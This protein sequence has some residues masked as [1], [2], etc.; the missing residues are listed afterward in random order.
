MNRLPYFILIV[1]LLTLSNTGFSQSYQW[2]LLGSRKVNYT[3]DRDV[4]PV[5]IRKESYRALKLVVKHGG[6]NL[7]KCIVHFENGAKEEI[8]VRHNFLR[9][10]SSRTIDLPGNKRFIEKIEFYYDS[11]NRSR[12]RAEILVYGGH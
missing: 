2:E 10:S 3:L 1:A 12:N 5:T 11:K 6:L 8:A 9:K 4:V 7:H